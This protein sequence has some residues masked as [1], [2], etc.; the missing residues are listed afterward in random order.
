MEMLQCPITKQLF[1]SPVLASDGHSY[2]KSAI[3]KWYQGHD[4]SPMTGVIVTKALV[5]NYALKSQVNQ[6]K[7]D[8]LFG[9]AGKQ[10]INALT[11]QLVGAST[12][13][14]AYSIVCR[15]SKVVS[16]NTDFC[17][18]TP[19]AVLNLKQ[20]VSSKRLVDSKLMVEFSELEQVC[21][22]QLVSM[23]ERYHTNSK[24]LIGCTIANDFMS[25]QVNHSKQFV[26]AAK[27]K[28]KQAKA[29]F[30]EAKQNVN[31]QKALLS[32]SEANLQADVDNAAD[33]G[34]MRSEYSST[35]SNME[36]QLSSLSSSLSLQLSLAVTSA[37]LSLVRRAASLCSSRHSHSE[38]TKQESS[39]E[40]HQLS[41]QVHQTRP[42]L[43]WLYE[44]GM[45]YFYGSELK[46]TLN[47]KRGK[48]F[49]EASA[50]SGFPMA[51]ATSKIWKRTKKGFLLLMKIEKETHYHW[52]QFMLGMCYADGH[53]IK[54]NQFKAQFWFD[55]ARKQGNSAK[56][57]DGLEN[58]SSQAVIQG[59]QGI[60]RPQ[61]FVL[62]EDEQFELEEVLIMSLSGADSPLSI[63]ELVGVDIPQS[64]YLQIQA[65]LNQMSSANI[66][67]VTQRSLSDPLNRYSLT[68][69]SRSFTARPA[70]IDQRRVQLAI[71]PRHRR[72]YGMVAPR[73]V[74]SERSRVNYDVVR[75]SRGRGHDPRSPV[76]F[77]HPYDDIMNLNGLTPP[78]F[79][80]SESLR[81]P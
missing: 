60:A 45:E 2:E 58:S 64:S 50:A 47:K 16:D 34:Q 53:G 70:R 24:K 68:S 52:A 26:H 57:H 66:V 74:Q 54:L 62:M 76:V 56:V 13:S 51:Q 10:T 42:E 25:K 65:T 63:E 77:A 79:Q 80:E 75:S 7:K 3:E 33:V 5:P 40:V 1:K 6:W 20:L 41:S 19:S 43:K 55:K 11:T 28:L 59:I 30:N 73:P 27:K 31:D 9:K 17:L 71:P 23:Q 78:T 32:T 48:M 29:K 12:T 81:S 35:K 4:T 39:S 72:R 61:E 44:E 15:I 14:D 37:G 49:I 67:R 18:M 36:V 38:E 69:G 46:T 8:Q 22:A 21:Q